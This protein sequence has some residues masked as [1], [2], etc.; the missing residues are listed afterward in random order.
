MKI[1]FFLSV[2]TMATGWA[3]VAPQTELYQQLKTNDSLLFSVG[4]NT[5]N[6]AAFEQLIAPDLE[7]YHDQGGATHTKEAFLDTF[8]RN[9]CGNPEFQSRRELQPNTLQ[10]FPLYANGTLYGALQMGTH[11]FFETFGDAPEKPGSIAQF[12]HLSLATPNGWMLKRVL[13]YDH[14]LP[15]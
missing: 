4:F 10:V 14:H 15:E 8:R 5:F 7:F 1:A 9:I 13:S 6:V 12:T 3:Q 2:F 11:R